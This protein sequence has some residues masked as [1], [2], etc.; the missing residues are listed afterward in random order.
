MRKAGDD[1]RGAVQ[2]D[3]LHAGG[4]FNASGGEIGVGFGLGQDGGALVGTGKAAVFL[5][6]QEFAIHVGDEGA[7]R[8]RASLTDSGSDQQESGGKSHDCIFYEPRGMWRVAF[9]GFREASAG[10]AAGTTRGFER[11]PVTLN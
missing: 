6:V 7:V 2:D 5:D 10:D 4:K 1:A 3:G 11:V 9:Y 8:R